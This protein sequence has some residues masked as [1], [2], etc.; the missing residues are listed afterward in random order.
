MYYLLCFICSWRFCVSN[1]LTMNFVH[2]CNYFQ[3]TSACRDAT[4]EISVGRLC[5]IYYL[6]SPGNLSNRTLLQ[7]GRKCGREN[8]SHLH[9]LY[10]QQ[11][12]SEAIF[13][14][15]LPNKHWFLTCMP[16]KSF[17]NNVG[18]EE[19]ASNEQFFLFS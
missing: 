11:C 18:K 3:C 7:N 14:N 9:F 1:L 13:I 17:E 15:P 4:L 5:R 2:L 16:C 6:S 8:A 19:I 10:F 12:F